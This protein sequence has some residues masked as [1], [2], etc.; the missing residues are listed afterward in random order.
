MLTLLTVTIQPYRGEISRII[1]TY[2]AADAPRQL[3][4]SD[5]DRRAVLHALSYTTHPSALRIAFRVVD[6]TLRKQAHPNFVRWSVCNGNPDRVWGAR[7]LGYSGIL[8]AF[9]VGI[10]LTLSH[11]GRGW[12][13]FGNIFLISGLCAVVASHR[14]MCICM[15]AM[16]NRHIRPWEFFVD[17]ECANGACEKGAGIGKNSTA[18]QSF[19]SFGSSNSFEDEPWVVDYEKKSLMRKIFDKETWI[20]DPT[21]RTIQDTIFLQSLLIALAA[22][23]AYTALFVP[24]PAGNFF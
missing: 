2:L 18:A 11:V 24:L 13:A 23:A 7:Q 12:R 3:N 19:E 9:V 5:R 10:V 22:D 14:G 1:A 15:Y 8:F 20:E 21:I 4:L 17:A 16:H 6:A